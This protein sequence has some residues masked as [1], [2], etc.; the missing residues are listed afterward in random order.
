V[1]RDTYILPPVAADAVPGLGS[2]LV[3]LYPRGEPGAPLPVTIGGAPAGNEARIGAIKLVPATPETAEP[4]QAIG[5]SFGERF[6]LLGYDAPESA[7]PGDTV[8][9]RLYW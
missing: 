7:S 5:V 9:L 2:L 4:S 6:D 8:A 3:I 1:F